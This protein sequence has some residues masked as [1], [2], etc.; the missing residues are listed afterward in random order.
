M[1]QM[2][3]TAAKPAPAA[4]RYNGRNIFAGLLTS[5]AILIAMLSLLAFF[6]SVAALR[7]ESTL[8]APDLS[9]FTQSI[10]A[11]IAKANP[12]GPLSQGAIQQALQNPSVIQQLSKSPQQGSQALNQQLSHLDPSLSQTLSKNPV[13]L[14]LGNNFI[15][16]A[17]QN[18]QNGAIWGALIAAGL[19]ILALLI[20]TRRDNVLRRIGKWAIWVSIFAVLFGWVLPWY[21]SM[22]VGG[23]IGSLASWYSDSQATAHTVYLLLLIG[24]LGAYVAGK[25]LKPRTV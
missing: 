8:S 20:S 23:L 21:I 9:N 3:A 15:A 19:V 4:P 18:L 16:G 12:N 22:H 11:Q 1:A 24:G 5:L 7:A 13:Q 25:I 17:Q 2:S 6:L 14:N 10:G